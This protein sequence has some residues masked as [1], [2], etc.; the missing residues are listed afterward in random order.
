MQ[1]RTQS[2]TH[3]RTAEITHMARGPAYVRFPLIFQDKVGR[4]L[5]LSRFHAYL[6]LIVLLDG[7]MEEF[8]ARTYDICS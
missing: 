1:A 7:I 3:T 8:T 2:R 4:S 5:P 6:D